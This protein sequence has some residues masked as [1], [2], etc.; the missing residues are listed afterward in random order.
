MPEKQVV[1]V[2][3]PK[4]GRSDRYGYQSQPPFTTPSSLNV[5][6]DALG[7]ERG[8]SRPGFIKAFSTIT[9][10][11]LLGLS[12][13]TYVPDSSSFI[14]T[15]LVAIDSTGAI[16]IDDGT[17]AT[18][19]SVG[20]IS[21]SSTHLLTMCER[22]QLLYIAC[23]SDDQTLSDTTYRLATFDPVD[24]TDAVVVA[25]AG[26]I[27][28]GC[29]CIC[30]WRDRIVLA[31]GTTHPYGIFMSRQS[32]PE[33]WDYSAE[34]DAAAVAVGVSDRTGLIGE[35]VT[36]LSPVGDDCLMIGC[37]TSL[38]QM[39]GD[40]LA[41]GRL[42][43][44]SREHGVVD[45]NAWCTTPDGLFVFLS[46][47]GLYATHAGC[48]GAA[49]KSLSRD[50]LPLELLNINRSTSGTIVS[51]AYDIRHRGIHIWVSDR[52]SANTDTGNSHWFLDWKGKAFYDVQ[53]SEARFDPWC[54]HSRKNFPSSESTVIAGCRDGYL[55]KYVTTADRDDDG[56]A[57][58][59]KKINSH[60]V[61]GPFGDEPD[62]SN[63]VRVDELEVIMSD[64]TSRANWAIFRGDTAEEALANVTA[65]QEAS[66]GDLSAGRSY[67][68][69]PRV[70]GA[71]IFLKIH[72]TA[73]WA[74]EACRIV[75]ARLG[76]TRM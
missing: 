16:F 70:R 75:L 11:S 12:S 49:P 3:W 60:V 28:R 21:V 29:P 48:G 2:P 22:N 59:E 72:S 18:I 40:P 24:N 31:G 5:W 4:G 44:I 62:L 37:P 25:A 35:T 54:A 42:V 7:R 57:S 50:R 74:F 76:R 64:D 55:R 14:K 38:W 6:P 63:D 56:D 9:G 10:G 19:S 65:A 73:A 45:R 68:F 34:D 52:T 61:L 33:D 20:S 26:T 53:Y 69:H 71:A 58:T 27:P 51:L 13:I 66:V 32:D 39:Q 41:G 47:D 15:K 36:S 46:A 1:R 17:G 30:T 67:R 8:G 43:N 23:H